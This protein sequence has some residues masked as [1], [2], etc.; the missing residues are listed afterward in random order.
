MARGPLPLPRTRAGLPGKQKHSRLDEARAVG[1][2]ALYM[3][4]AMG[5]LLFYAGVFGLLTGAVGHYKGRSFWRFFLLGAFLGII[6]FIVSLFFSRNQA[7]LDR[8]AVE[9]G[10]AK[11]CPACAETI[12]PEARKCFHCGAEMMLPGDPPRGR[13]APEAKPKPAR[14][15]IEE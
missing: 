14:F 9:R 1:Y 11:Y 13:T 4:R 8:R 2:D 5:T 3:E 12:K 10:E 7:E 15:V 6:G